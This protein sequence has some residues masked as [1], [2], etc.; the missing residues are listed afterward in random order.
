MEVYIYPLQ[1]GYASV[2]SDWTRIYFMM[3][4]LYHNGESSFAHRF[5]YYCS[6]DL[7]ATGAAISI[8]DLLH[9]RCAYVL[10]LFKIT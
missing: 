10:N 5:H 1:E 4:Y 9:S 3:F 2:V 8:P 7:L 6:C